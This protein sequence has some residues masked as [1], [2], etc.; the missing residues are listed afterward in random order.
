M[1]TVMKMIIIK[2]KFFEDISGDLLL[3][4][5]IEL[6]EKEGRI[7]EINADELIFSSTLPLQNLSRDETRRATHFS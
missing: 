4:A 7:R 2:Q 1:K 6:K 5:F 3:L